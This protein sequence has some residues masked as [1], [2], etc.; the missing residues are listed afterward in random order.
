MIYK[1]GKKRDIYVPMKRKKKLG[2]VTNKFV[3]KQE[4]KRIKKFY[5]L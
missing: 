5:L 4:T 3:S 1:Y 2:T